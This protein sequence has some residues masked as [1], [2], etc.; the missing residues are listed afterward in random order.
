MP[1]QEWID[2]DRVVEDEIA[3][4]YLHGRLSETLQE[5]YERHYFDCERCFEELETYRV[6]QEAL[7]RSAAQSSEPSAL[8]HRGPVRAWALAAAVI[9]VVAGLAM[10]VRLDAPSGPRLSP[11]EDA[12]E[13]P[14]GS[15]DGTTPQRA[16]DRTNRPDE[17]ARQLDRLAGV[18]PPPYSPVTL[19]GDRTGA[20][21]AF[22]E[23]MQSYLEG[24]Y[25]L[26]AD[27]LADAA[28]L[29]P[30]RPDIAFFH[31]ASLLL[32]GKVDEALAALQSTLQLG[33]SPFFEEAHFYR[34]KACLANRDPSAARDHLRRV[35]DAG[36]P[37]AAEAQSLLDELDR[38]PGSSETD[39]ER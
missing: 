7:R 38:L 29:D 18:E 35:V 21:S 22:R 3:E 14:D 16:E 34:A 2:C 30:G 32:V 11:V 20:D 13:E 26:A 5:A 31:G 9:V 12:G 15:P 27:G 23:A 28:A 39:G 10:L 19:R 37:L 1:P 6:I 24:R 25:D 36:G 4:R 17:A 8:W 33:D